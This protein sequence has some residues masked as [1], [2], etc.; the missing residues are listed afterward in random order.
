M[1]MIDDIVREWWTGRDARGVESKHAKWRDGSVGGLASRVRDPRSIEMLSAMLCTAGVAD[2]V[3]VRLATGAD[4]EPD[5]RIETETAGVVSARRWRPAG[6]TLDHVVERNA[7]PSARRR[8]DASQRSAMLAD[9]LARDPSTLDEASARDVLTMLKQ[10]R[11]ELVDAAEA[12]ADVSSDRGAIEA[13]MATVRAR[14]EQQLAARKG[15]RA[16]RSGSVR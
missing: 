3:R 2:Y 8:A 16:A 13:R 14:Y 7:T 5:V 6:E 10:R 1:M 4:G 12:G 11:A 15:D 9:A